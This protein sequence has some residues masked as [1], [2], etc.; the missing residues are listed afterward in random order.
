MFCVVYEF[1]V[2]QQNEHLFTKVWHQLTEI[3]KETR[4]GLGSRLHKDT[5]RDNVWIA[6]AQWP[7]KET[8]NNNPS[9]INPD[10]NILGARIKDLCVSIQTIY[11]LNMID[12]LLGVNTAVDEEK[13]KASLASHTSHI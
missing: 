10:H 12:D 3:I 6:Y 9:S 8:W 4:G 2:P 5:K 13:I 1:E 11:E 7:N